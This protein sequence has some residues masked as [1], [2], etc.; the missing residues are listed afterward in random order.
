MSNT[1]C[2]VGGGERERVDGVFVCVPVMRVSERFV[3][4]SWSRPKI[5]VSKS[6]EYIAQSAKPESMA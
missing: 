2:V 4:V 3:E 6:L 5:G 1:N